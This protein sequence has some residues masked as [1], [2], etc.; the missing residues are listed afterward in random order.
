MP[1]PA[2]RICRAAR[3][4]AQ[5]VSNPQLTSF[6]GL[7]A[8][9]SLGGGLLVVNNSALASL[10]GLNALGALNAT[11]AASLHGPKAR[12]PAHHGAPRAPHHTMFE[13]VN[14]NA[15]GMWASATRDRTLSGLWR[16]CARAQQGRPAARRGAR[17]ARAAAQVLGLDAIK[18]S[19]PSVLVTGNPALADVSALARLAGCASGDPSGTTGIVLEVH[20]ADQGL[21]CTLVAWKQVCDYIA[22]GNKAR[23]PAHTRRRSCLGSLLAA[24]QALSQHVQTLCRGRAGGWYAVGRSHAVRLQVPSDSLWRNNGVCLPA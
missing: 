23:P 2:A 12:P 19:P 24:R 20:P 9:S 15:Q 10:E 1:L 3:A 7:D 18:L 22:A 5:V 21:K 11:G 14:C 4:A 8:L 13:P 17:P 16:A 6:K